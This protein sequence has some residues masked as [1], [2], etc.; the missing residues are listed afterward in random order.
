MKFYSH[1]KAILGIGPILLHKDIRL[2]Q[3][4]LLEVAPFKL[5]S[6]YESMIR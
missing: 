6:Q 3:K 4:K 1:G 5:L 2:L